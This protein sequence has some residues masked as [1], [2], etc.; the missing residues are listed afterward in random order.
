V[1]WAKIVLVK[2]Q[3]RSVKALP[4]TPN[5][6]SLGESMNARGKKVLIVL[7]LRFTRYYY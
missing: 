3:K 7:D 5:L 4:Y 6:R 1:F 2:R